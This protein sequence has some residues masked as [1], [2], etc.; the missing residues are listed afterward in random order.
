MAERGAFTAL[1]RATEEGQRSVR[2]LPRPFQCLCAAC[3]AE[4]DSETSRLLRG[5]GVGD[6]SSH[7][8]STRILP[9]FVVERQGGEGEGGTAADAAERSAAR[10]FRS[11]PSE[12][13]PC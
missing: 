8:E 5:V 13:R 11:A 7:A 6:V 3:G 9:N 4:T 12:V 2:E 1:L 10:R